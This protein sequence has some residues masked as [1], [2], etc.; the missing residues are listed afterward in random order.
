MM[1]KLFFPVFRFVWKLF[2]AI[3]TAI[4]CGKLLKNL[5]K[6]LVE[7]FGKICDVLDKESKIRGV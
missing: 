3:A 4:S 5:L 6:G 1:G 2:I 7:A